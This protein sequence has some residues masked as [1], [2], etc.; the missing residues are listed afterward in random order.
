MMNQFLHANDVDPRLAEVRTENGALSYK[1]FGS[2]L[3]NQ[4]GKAGGYRHRPIEDVWADQSALWAED[5]HIALLFPFYL[6][7]IT[8]KPQ[9]VNTEKVQR[10]PGNRD[11]SFKRLLWIAKYHPDEFYANLWLIPL[12]GSWKDIWE[13]MVMGDDGKYLDYKR[14][15]DVLNSGLGCDTTSELVK[16][17]LP[18]IRS[19][20]K[21]V[22]ERAKKLNMLAKSFAYYCG[23]TPKQYRLLKTGGTAHKFQ[24]IICDKRY[25]ELDWKTIP[26]KALL[27]LVNG[28]FLDRHNLVESY[29][30][31][32]NSQDTIKFNGYPYELSRKLQNNPSRAT[33]LTVNKQF[34]ELIS[35]GKKDGGAITGN[36]LCALDTSGSM[37][38]PIDIN[39]S[40]TAFDVCV[41]LGIY[42]SALNTGAFKDVVAMFDDTSTLMTLKGTFN[43]KLQQ[44]LRARTAWG[45]TNFQSLIDLIVRTRNKHPEIPLEDYPKTLLVVSDMQFNP[46][47]WG[48]RVSEQT[49]YETAM[50]KLRG[51]FPKEFVDDFKIIWWFCTNR[52]TADFPSNCECGG[53]YMMSGFDGATVSFIIGG[54]QQDEKKKVTK[55]MEDVINEAFSQDI[56]SLI[57]F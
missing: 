49:N 46:S 31:W 18:Q 23:L 24:T 44:I 54:E 52:Y 21:C 42:F 55:T 32:V 8:R 10:G 28:K 11:E 40:L 56:F 37:A 26:G 53:T 50:A 29:V 43:D 45:S 48:N 6:R 9:L 7:L 25:D 12:F 57:K 22:T 36:V 2:E 13:I 19:T 4:F 33:V 17:Y 20:K 35:T 14:F 15:F 5:P 16:K 38:S 30:D 34:D 3:M 1:T 41:S 27:N 39:G 51:A 47:G